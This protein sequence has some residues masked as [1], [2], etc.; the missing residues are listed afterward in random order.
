MQMMNLLDE[1]IVFLEMLTAGLCIRGVPPKGDTYL[2]LA[3][4]T[5][6]IQ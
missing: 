5:K 2:L 6:L 4:N 1:L 3:V